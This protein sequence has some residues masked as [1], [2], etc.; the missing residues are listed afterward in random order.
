VSVNEDAFDVLTRHRLYLLRYEAGVARALV[1]TYDAALADVLAEMEALQGAE[2]VDA[3]RAARLLAVSKDL[4]AKI[5][6]ANR[7]A[8]LTLQERLAETAEAEADLHAGRL[9]RTI[10]VAFT[11]VPE[12]VVAAAITTPIGGGRWTQRL[13]V[14]LVEAHD[15]IRGAI[16]EGIASGG[17]M[18]RIARMIGDVTGLTAT[19]RGRLVAIARTEVQRVANDVALASYVEN[20]DVIS[21][22]EVVGTLDSRT[23]LA[24]APLHGTVYQME[25]GRPVGMTRRPPFHPRCRCFL[26][27]VVKSYSELVGEPTRPPS[28]YTGRPA[29]DTTFD[30]WLRRQPRDVQEDVLGPARLAAWRS[31]TPLGAFVDN[32]R[33]LGLGELRRRGTLDG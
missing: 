32:G 31:G 22:V 11:R 26:A 10:G 4:E 6:E 19:Y 7:V 15:L 13:A 2:T 21:G 1:A 16:A 8:A 18:D 14:D 25:G 9:A 17:S 30:A 12:A 23:C 33:I 3:D 28:A 29:L 27:P 24:C 5:R 20:A